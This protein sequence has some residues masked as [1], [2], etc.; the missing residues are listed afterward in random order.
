MENGCYVSKLQLILDNSDTFNLNI[1]SSNENTNCVNYNS[2]S[3]TGGPC[4]VASMHYNDDD[5]NLV[6]GFVD[7][8]RYMM[9]DPHNSSACLAGVTESSVVTAYV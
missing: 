1:T 8:R 9:F 2:G 5:G 4:F 3:P 6:K 7:E